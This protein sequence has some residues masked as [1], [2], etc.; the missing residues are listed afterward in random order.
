MENAV[1]KYPTFWTKAT[2]IE[3]RSEVLL[4]SHGDL[5]VVEG[6]SLTGVLHLLLSALSPEVLLTQPGR[7]VPHISPHVLR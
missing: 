4:V 5:E 2:V 1:K 7:S 3:F 6:L